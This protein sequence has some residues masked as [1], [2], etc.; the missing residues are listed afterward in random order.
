VSAGGNRRLGVLG[1]LLVLAGAL[2]VVVL[3]SRAPAG[4]PFDARS[5]APGGYAALVDLLG[6]RG[7]EV[8]RAEA[9][10][11][12]QRPLGEGDVVVVPA[13]GLTSRAERTL[14]RAGAAAGAVVVW[15]EPPDGAFALPIP[16]DARTLADTPADPERPGR[17]DAAG[18]G[19]LGPVDVAFSDRVAVPDGATSCF[20]DGRLARV[21]V[22]DVGDGRVVTLG[23]PYLLVNARLW[24]DKEGGGQPLDNAALGL[25]LMDGSLTGTGVPTRVTFVDAVPSPSAELG[26]PRNPVELLPWPIKL[27]VLVGFG[28]FVIYAWGRA[29]RL[30]APVR[31]RVPVEVAGSELV[32]AVGDLLR[33]R[34]SPGPAAADLRAEVRRTLS[35]RLGLPPAAPVDSLVAVVSARTG[36]PPEE[37]AE[38]LADRPVASTADLVG[39]AHRLDSLR[40]E[41]LDGRPVG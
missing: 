31:E 22:E 29:R 2:A 11:V 39:L 1:V 7:V 36:R 14:L 17:C 10:D 3:G 41:V 34:S 24:P 35:T 15:G 21:V 30:G 25:R 20:G 38:L 8:R 27:S 16:V 13:P 26:G 6:A 19:G 28:A 32:V 40:Q 37:V 33:R 23:S 9:S 4:E 5:P 12:V 18:L